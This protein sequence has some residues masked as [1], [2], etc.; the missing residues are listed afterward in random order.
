MFR[1]MLI[2]LLVVA[3]DDGPLDV[4]GDGLG[5]VAHDFQAPD[6][7]GETVRFHDFCAKTIL[8]VNGTYG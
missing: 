7:F 4:D 3:C 8:L 1:W 5:Q 6:Q 2:S